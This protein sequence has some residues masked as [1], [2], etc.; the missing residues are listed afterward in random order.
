MREAFGVAGYGRLGLLI[1]VVVV[2]LPTMAWSAEFI[3]NGALLRAAPGGSWC[4]AGSNAFGCWTLTPDNGGGTNY[5]A[6][7]FWP[8]TRLCGCA[9]VP[10]QIYPEISQSFGISGGGTYTLTWEQRNDQED[11]SSRASMW[12]GM[13]GVG[14]VYYYKDAAMTNPCSPASQDTG[15]VTGGAKGVW[16]PI[17]FSNTGNAPLH[18][19]APA[20]CRYIRVA[21]K[22][23]A[24]TNSCTA[25]GGNVRA[26]TEIRNVSFTSTDFAKTSGPDPI[27]SGHPA[28]KLATVG[29]QVTFGVTAAG[30]GSVS[31]QWQ[32][33]PS[34]GSFA[35]ISGV[36]SA[37]YTT[38]ALVAGDSGN[39]YRCAV[40]NVCT[41]VYSNAATLT[42]YAPVTVPTVAGAKTYAD[43][44]LVK[45][46]DK[47]VSVRTSTAYWI[48]DADPPCGIKIASAAYPAPGSRMTVVGT[49]GTT[50]RERWISP[51]IETWGVAGDPVR[52]YFLTTRSLGGADLNEFSLGVPG[53]LGSNNIGLLVRI[54][55]SVSN[56][57]GNYYYVDDGAALADGTA[58]DNLGVRIMAPP[59]GLARND[60][61]AVTGASSTF[62]DG[63]SNVRR[64]IITSGC[65]MPNAGLTVGAVASVFCSGGS[66]SITV[67]STEA[68]V[69]YQ[70]RKNSGNVLVANP[71]SGTGGT[72]SFPTGTLTSTTTFNVLATRNVGGCSVQISSTKTITVNPLLNAA[73]AVGASQTRPDVG[74]ST[75][76]TVANSQSGVNYQLRNN[77]SNANVGSPVAGTGGTIN[78]PTGTYTSTGVYVYNV[79]AA[80]ASTGC[81]RQLTQ[82]VSITVGTLGTLT[83][84]VKTA[85]M[86]PISGVTVTTSPAT[87]TATTGADGSYTLANVP[88]GTYNIIASKTGY[89]THTW[90][91]EI[92]TSGVTATVQ[93]HLLPR[94]C[95]KI[96]AHVIIGRRD[97]W[98]AF[99]TTTQNCGKACQMVKCVDDFGAANDAR[100][101]SPETL[102]VG[103]IN[104]TPDYDMQGFDYYAD[105]ASAGYTPPAQFAQVIFD[106]LTINHPANYWTPNAGK[107]DLWEICNEWSWW[108][109]YQA[110]FYIAMMDIAEAHGYRIAMYGCSAGNPPEAFWPEIARACRRAK[111]QGGHMLSLHEYSWDD[112]LCHEINNHP[113]E[114]VLRYR[115]L[116]DYLRSVDADCPLVLTECGNNGGGGYIGDSA[117]VADM[118][119]YDDQVRQDDYVFGIAS[120]TLGNWSGANW[121]TALPGMATYICAH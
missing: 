25:T 84:K 75:N 102:T 16:A 6:D 100:S 103:R 82:T 32:K 28:S 62:L 54:Y 40:S 120:W 88:A 111:A 117:F 89:Q 104:D 43:G 47:P 119:C 79:L 74:Q 26:W 49:L 14:T 34:G 64:A 105:P 61:I 7:E 72:I 81:S 53:A 107:I 11:C 76:V 110:D 99:L 1:L 63:A 4:E 42:V 8:D 85:R 17:T 92:V 13:T 38:A 69:T 31:Y 94:S 15:N 83:G 109:A 114:L 19:T 115:R 91:Y 78:L 2:M 112:T 21:I 101:L 97:G 39:Q 46:V 3:A 57:A 52:P 90:Y 30:P 73:L 59:G 96:G 44:T 87:V 116:Y 35:D 51:V 121:Y 71:V 45:V 80:N 77:A 12:G 27:I 29:D 106:E 66:T 50:A 10:C 24:K 67:A 56:V 70:L 86:L 108:W 65:T 113:G 36:K 98:G 60:M 37:S 20:D 22:A 68:D 5:S 41:T 33:K 118:A 58:A 9:G 55:G 48:Q 23:L 18:G 95:S 93:D